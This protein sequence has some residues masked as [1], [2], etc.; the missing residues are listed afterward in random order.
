MAQLHHR[1][2]RKP[3]FLRSAKDDF[4]PSLA[5]ANAT[6]SQSPSGDNIYCI[7]SLRSVL[8]KM[9]KLSGCWAT[10]LLWNTLLG[11]FSLEVS[12]DRGRRMKGLHGRV[13]VPFPTQHGPSCMHPYRPW[14]DTLWPTHKGLL[15]DQAVPLGLSYL[16]LFG[17]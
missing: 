11:V 8:I 14:T 3:A 2:A 16:F 15:F 12:V 1:G 10:G 5:V 6:E 4:S 9:D 7:S 13:H 17:K